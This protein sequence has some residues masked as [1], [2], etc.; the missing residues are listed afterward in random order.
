VQR[1]A[2]EQLN[3]AQSVELLGEL[4]PKSAAAIYRHGGGNPFYLEQLARSRDGATL[5]TNF[6]GN[7]AANA[8]PTAVAA[9]LAEEVAALS[10]AERAL[11]EAAAVAGEPF[12]PDLASAIAELS[13][14][15]GLV[16]LDAL[17]ALDL[18]RPTAVPRRFVFRHPLVRRAVYDSAP[19][20]W[21]LAAHARAAAALAARG[22]APSERA[23]HVEQSAE[24][25]DEE[26]IQLLLDA[27]LSVAS[28]APAAAVQ[29]FG[30]VLRLLPASDG[31]RQVD[32]R[33]AL[34]SALR[35]LG[36]L[37]RCRAT[38]L[39]AVELLPPDAVARR[40]E[41]IALCAA[42]EHWLGRHDEAHRR[43]T[44]AWEELPD[45]GTAEAAAVQIE[46]AVDGLYVHDFDQA[47]Q[48]GGYA[49]DT[50]RALGDQGL[51][52]AAAS[53]LCFGE[54]AAGRIDEAR[55]HRAE[56]LAHVDGLS[57]AELAP[58]LE[59]LYYLGWAETYLEHYDDAVGHFA[60]GVAIAREIGDGRLLVPMTLGPNFTFEMTGRLAE[61]TE[62]CETVL[63]AV[64]LSNSPHELYR[65]LFELGWTRYYAG[66]LDGAIAVYEE[67]S[68]VDPRLAG[69]TIPNAGG[70]PGWGL[71]VSW[72]E[73]GEIER[74]RAV[75]LELAAD[76]VA[77]T[78]PVERCFDWENL[79]LVELA[80]GNAEAAEDYATRSE[81]DAARLGLKLPA[82]LAGRAR[83]AV[84]LAG[85]QPHEAARVARE[86]AEAA[87]EI[88]ARLHVA[89]SRSL[90]GRAL[91]A[92]GEREQAIAV[93]RGAETELDL[94]GSVR[95]RDE[96][97]RELRKLG[98]RAEPRGP[99][100]TGDVGVSSL[101][102]RELEIA[103]L[104]TDRRTNREI[105]S[106][107]FLSEKTVE[108]H[109]RHIFIKLGVSSRVEV[110][111]AV[112]R[113]RALHS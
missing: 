110:A 35:S 96:M 42:V 82:A 62:I 7:D 29:W 102:E 88:G 87:A 90:E 51:I 92:A 67:C 81:E 86:S 85:E 77:L 98:A 107:L 38:L 74:G 54:T 109:M 68:R 50:A 5:A 61:A 59:A 72:F 13:P 101:T 30:T 55:E 15:E 31:Q 18:L 11:L 48:A 3:E 95:V 20:G 23:H 17:L 76:E 60:R 19:G 16:A 43:L 45:R 66:D 84:L 103:T 25:G 113:E 112:E 94:C 28:R 34:A 73:A 33:V 41:L 80:V 97:R 36:E 53:A 44:H 39:E 75:L 26:A 58:R 12:E 106:A 52:A 108:S 40:V 57:D 8:V 69:G 99:A 32:V 49:L 100:S 6:G 64:R 21:R 65:A 46:L 10:A 91:V 78:M 22:A 111:R 71:G 24:Q 1:I 56:A 9:S 27:G 93:L 104:A 14:S 37:E 2:L 105:A 47:V 63:E 79:T 70:G 89:F 83:A 4:D